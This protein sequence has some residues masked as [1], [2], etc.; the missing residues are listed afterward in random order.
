MSTSIPLTPARFR[1]KTGQNINKLEKT[2]ISRVIPEMTDF[3]SLARYGTDPN[4][5]PV[6]FYIPLC[7]A[8]SK[9]LFAAVR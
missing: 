2:R 6:H 4:R 9:V 8:Y 7:I 1:E 5:C 3:Q